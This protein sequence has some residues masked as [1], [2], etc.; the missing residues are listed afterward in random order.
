MPESSEGSKPIRFSFD[1]KNREAQKIA[2]EYSAAQITLID[3]ETKLAIRQ[4]IARSIRDGIPPRE[5]ARLI[6]DLVGLNRPQAIQLSDYSKRLDPNMKAS[7]RRKATERLAQKLI[8]R[9][10]VMIARTEVIDALNTGADVA[11]KQAQQQGILGKTAKKEWIATTGACEVCLELASKDPVP[12][13]ASF[14]IV[15]GKS[16]YR[17]TAHPNCRCAVAPV[18]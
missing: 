15:R 17:P 6:R 2:R 3:T 16:L 13:K 9:R 18:P 10:A 4:I 1:A 11:W 14:G 8:R 7:V 12:L 5:A